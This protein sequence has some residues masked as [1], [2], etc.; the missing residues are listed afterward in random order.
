MRNKKLLVLLIVTAMVFT[1]VPSFAVSV[2]YDYDVDATVAAAESDVTVIPL[3]QATFTRFG[4]PAQER[5]PLFF[6]DA[7]IGGAH[8]EAFLQF[9]LAD[10]KYAIIAGEEIR[11]DIRV[12]ERVQGD[13]AGLYILPPYLADFDMY[14]LD[15]VM[16]GVRKPPSYT[17]MSN[18]AAHFATSFVP[19][20]GHHTVTHNFGSALRDFW[21]IYPEATTITLRVS[22]LHAHSPIIFTFFGMNGRPSQEP[23]LLFGPNSADGR[24][25]IYD[26]DPPFEWRPD[27]DPNPVEFSGGIGTEINPFIIT[28]AEQLAY[29]ARRVNVHDAHYSQAYYRLEAD[30]DLSEFGSEFNDGAGWTPIGIRHPI[31][32][33]LFPGALVPTSPFAGVFDGNNHTITGLY[34]NAPTYGEENLQFG[35]SRPVGLFGITGHS[36]IK[37]LNVVDA[38]VTGR[39]A[40]IIAGELWSGSVVNVYTS[41]TVTSTNAF[42]NSSS[43]NVGGIVGIM[44]NGSIVERSSSSADVFGTALRGGL[45]GHIRFGTRISN[46]YA[47]GNVGNISG[48]PASAINIV[49]NSFFLRNGNVVAY[50]WNSQRN[51]SAAE[52]YSAEFWLD[53]IELNPHIWDIEDGRLPRLWRYSDLDLREQALAPIISVWETRVL[54]ERDA[55]GNWNWNYVQI[56]E[57]R[58][59]LDRPTSGVAWIHYT[60][61]GSTPTIDSPSVR[62]GGR[63]EIPRTRAAQ[64][65]AIVVQNGMRDSEVT[66]LNIAARVAG[67]ITD[68]GEVGVADFLLLT[69]YLAG[70][71]ELTPEQL[72]FAAVHNYNAGVVDTRDAIRLAQYL[73]GVPGVYLGPRQYPEE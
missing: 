8:R 51:V 15:A 33:E 41:G 18:N 59:N 14:V 9:D 66:E 71:I 20:D 6:V 32:I 35:P 27:P 48:T 60:L 30:I 38:N 73:A 36:I 34:I 5:R 68:T 69:Q 10:Y 24:G 43:A 11:L 12:N 4:M 1:F 46:S 13:L 23:V 62:S 3:T 16:A 31:P 63:I 39:T 54:S 47:T 7:R 52:A 22:G 19:F 21:K 28:T 67:D 61:D 55:Y 37:N 40:G 64:I 50:G 17:S 26:P 44:E 53:T 49:E 56:V 2:G 70:V 58:M 65:R 29:L 42:V 57:F 25:D 72:F 45:V